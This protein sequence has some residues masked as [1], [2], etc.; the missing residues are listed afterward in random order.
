MKTREKILLK[1]YILCL[2]SFLFLAS[3]ATTRIFPIE[4]GSYKIIVSSAS[5]SVAYESALNDIK[6]YCG[7]KG[8]QYEVI[9]DKAEYTGI[10]KSTK[11]MV[12][13]SDSLSRDMVD[14][15]HSESLDRNDDNRVTITFRCTLNQLEG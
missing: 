13:Q 15:K 6:G 10:D 3:C 4:G 7:N 9:K 2:C 5:E 11:A 12:E 14:F 1:K 8:L